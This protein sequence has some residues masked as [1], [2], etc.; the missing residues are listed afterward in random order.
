MS[1]RP[2]A[3]PARAW[4]A[5]LLRRAERAEDRFDSIVSRPDI[6]ICRALISAASP[7]VLMPFSDPTILPMTPEEPALA[8]D[9]VV[10][11]CFLCSD[12]SRCRLV[13]SSSPVASS[14]ADF[15]A[16]SASVMGFFLRDV[17]SANIEYGLETL[18]NPESRAMSDMP[19]IPMRSRHALAIVSGVHGSVT[20]SFHLNPRDMPVASNPCLPLALLE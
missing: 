14:P 11:A 12:R 19:I 8:L 13:T 16:I 4:A 6:S 18:A 17:L 9:S 7:P 2:Q 1:K 10:A 3:V 15:L 5:C 20:P